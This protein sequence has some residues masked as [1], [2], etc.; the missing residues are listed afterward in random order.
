VN[1]GR[2]VEG[3]RTVAAS[4]FDT[5]KFKM[6]WAA[7]RSGIYSD[8]YFVNAA[9]V[10]SKLSEERVEFDGEWP[11]EA[12]PVR[13]R[14]R[15]HPGEAHVEMQFFT[16]R[17]PMSI[18]AGV[19]PAIAVLRNCTGF[20]DANGQ[21]QS[22]GDH[23]EIHAVAPG[24]SVAPNLPVMRVRGRFRSFAAL[25]TPVLGLLGRCT[26]VATNCYMTLQAAGGK[27]VFFFA[28]RHD[29][30]VTQAADGYAYKVAVD[31]YNARHNADVTP[32]VSTD[33]QGAWWEGTGGGTMSHSYILS[34]LRDTAR[35][36]LEFARVLPLEVKRVALVDTSNN[37]PSD[38]VKTACA[39]FAKYKEMVEAGRVHEAEKYVLFGVRVDTAENMLDESINREEATSRDYGPSPRLV[40]NVR[41]ALDNGHLSM[42]LSADWRKK[43]QEYFSQIKICVSGGLTPEKIARFERENVPVDM[44]G[45]G[46]YLLTG[47]SNDYT[48][49][50][51][52]VKVG[53][54]WIDMAK[55]GRH[56]VDNPAMKLV[57]PP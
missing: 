56:R 1:I 57:P 10:L 34:F 35:A 20:R 25:E 26:R 45:V 52:A 9:K 33:A 12:E 55:V 17:K 28:A 11:P 39:M 38:A 43:A 40:H 6:D 24:H 5:H 22:T 23:L 21:F 7:L 49:D 37:C 31:T 36:S 51:V 50:V 4:E 54:V 53:N 18:V 8:K 42:D 41:L 27:P 13:G 19:K 44:Y 32:L 3:N 16:K 29:L 2:H 30:Y 46:S 15:F 14:V 47:E 48:A